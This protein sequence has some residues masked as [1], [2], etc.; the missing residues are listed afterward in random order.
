MIDRLGFLLG[1]LLCLTPLFLL[2]LGWL[3]W[4]RVPVKEG[5]RKWRNYAIGM[6]LTF[7]SVSCVCILGVILYLRS[8]HLEY[9]KEYLLASAWGRFN[10]PVSLCA[11]IL[12]GIGKGRSRILLLFAALALLVSWTMAF[13]N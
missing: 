7:A 9:W 2:C 8:A 11:V 13:I 3:R 4:F 1:D 5:T 10:W 12:A 6:G